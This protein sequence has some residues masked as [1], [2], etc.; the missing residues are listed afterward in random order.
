MD[1]DSKTFSDLAL[2]KAEQEARER[3]A[4]KSADIFESEA[5]REVEEHERKKREFTEKVLAEK[6]QREDRQVANQKENPQAYEGQEEIKVRNPSF[7]VGP[8]TNFLLKKIGSRIRFDLLRG[9]KVEGKLVGLDPSLGQVIVEGRGDSPPSII[10]LQLKD[11][12]RVE[13]FAN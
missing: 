13:I 4:R 8:R 12:V 7:S 2:D 5:R 9:P 10:F 6:A 3:E 11:V 1:Q